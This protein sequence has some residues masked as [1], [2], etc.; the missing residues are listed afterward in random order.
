[1]VFEIIGKPVKLL[2]FAGSLNGL[3][4]P[5]TL[6]TILID[7]TRTDVVENYKHS[8]WLLYTGCLVVIIAVIGGWM[9]L[10]G[11]AGLWK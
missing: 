10:K 6:G 5:I 8:K 1:M 3:I 7:A 11:I 2:I 9:S 4:L